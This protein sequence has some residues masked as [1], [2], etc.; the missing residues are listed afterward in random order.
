MT[1]TEILEKAMDFITNLD[2]ELVVG[3]HDG[4]KKFQLLDTYGGNLKGIEKETFDN[5]GD[6]FDRLCFCFKDV[7]DFSSDFL[8]DE[9]VYSTMKRIRP[10]DYEEY[11]NSF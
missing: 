4:I 1:R 9:Q 6:V 5:L 11:L 10:S 7:A 8:S 3:V 2:Y